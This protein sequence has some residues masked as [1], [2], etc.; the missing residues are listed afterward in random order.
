MKELLA[1]ARTFVWGRAA[2]AGLAFIVLAFCAA[3][4]P[5]DVGGCNQ[6]AEELDP[7]AFFR[8]KARIDC[9]RCTECGFDTQACNR[10][11]QRQTQSDFPKDCLP[12]AHDGEVCLRA[13]LSASC[14]DYGDYVRDTAPTVPTECDFCPAVS[15]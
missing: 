14:G 8:T 7:Q 6:G 2:R 15:K 13:L 9:E 10:A 12:L 3:P 11:C 4:V 5:G 1:W